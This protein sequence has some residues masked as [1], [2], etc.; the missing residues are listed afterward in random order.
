MPLLPPL[1]LGY[2][3]LL[4]L[5]VVAPVSVLA[6]P[7]GVRV[8][9]QLSRRALEYIFM[10]FL[11]LVAARFAV[12]LALES[13][14]RAPIQSNRLPCLIGSFEI[15]RLD[16]GDI[17]VVIFPDVIGHPASQVHALLL[18]RVGF[19]VRKWALPQPRRV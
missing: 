2:V 7:L 3:N 17:G 12:S 10:T 19:A 11:L 5:V 18:I 14:V 15:A 16:E 6:A 9:H 4:G 13:Q 8:A 1:S